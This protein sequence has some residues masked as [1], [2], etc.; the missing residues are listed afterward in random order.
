MFRLEIKHNKAREYNN[1]YSLL[2]KILL[3]PY[4]LRKTSAIF[5]D[6]TMYLIYQKFYTLQVQLI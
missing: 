4:M 6:T 3:W 5:R 2:I 1:I